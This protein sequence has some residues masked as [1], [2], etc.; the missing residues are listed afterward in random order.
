MPANIGELHVPCRHVS[1]SGGIIV[2]G[3]V[4][5]DLTSRTEKDVCQIYGRFHHHSRRQ[6]NSCWQ[7]PLTDL[8][9]SCRRLSA[10]PT[11]QSNTPRHIHTPF[12]Q[13]LSRWTLLVG[14]LDFLSIPASSFY[15]I[16]HG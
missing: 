10:N 7:D 13:P 1:R 15:A 4:L 12:Q 2:H 6:S 14:P 9:C 5:L 3:S 8:S 16:C 11:H